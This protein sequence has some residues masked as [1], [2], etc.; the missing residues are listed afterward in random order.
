MCCRCRTEKKL[1]SSAPDN[2]RFSREE[3]GASLFAASIPRFSSTGCRI[4]PFY[5]NTSV[6]SLQLFPFPPTS[7]Q[8]HSWK[9]KVAGITTGDNIQKLPAVPVCSRTASASRREKKLRAYR[10]VIRQSQIIERSLKCLL[11]IYHTQAENASI[12]LYLL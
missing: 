6:T 1:R 7:D 5:R 10:I 8:A 11:K 4:Q 3:G 2:W 9:R 12:T